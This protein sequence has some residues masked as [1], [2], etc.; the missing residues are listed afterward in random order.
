MAKPLADLLTSR[1]LRIWYDAFSLKVGDS[2]R[3][4]IEHGLERS[5]FGI[6]IISPNFFRKEWPQRELDML[7]QKQIRSKRKKILPVW[8]EVDQDLIAKKSLALVDLKATK[9][10]NGLEKV[11]DEIL[12]STGK[13][14]SVQP[15][16]SSSLVDERFKKNFS[17]KLFLLTEVLAHK[18][19]D[20]KANE[21]IDF[22]I[23]LVKERID[24]WDTASVKFA[25]K[26]L[27]MK[28][29]KFSETNGL[30]DLYSIFKDLFAR[31]YSERSQLLGEMVDSFNV[32]MLG[33]WVPLSDVE[34][35]EKAAKIM[36]KLAMDFL[37]TDVKI[38]EACVIAIDNLA[39]DMFEPEILSK[40]ILLA[41][42]AF[43]KAKEKSE[44]QSFV[45]GLSS[46]I[47]I[48]DTYAWDAEIE[49]Y[50]RDSIAYADWEQTTF[51]ISLGRF[52][53][54]ILYP[55]LQQTIDEQIQNYADFFTDNETD[56]QDLSYE[57]QL[58]ARRILAY[59]FL[60]PEIAKEIRSKV[61]ETGS[62]TAQKTFEKMIHRSPFLKAIYGD[63]EM[64]TTFDGLLKFFE[65]NAD[66]ENLGIGLTTY[67]F[68]MIDFTSKL[69]DS[70][71]EALRGIAQ[72][73]GV[74][75]DLELLDQG[76][77]FEMDSLVYLGEGQGNDMKKLAPFLS[78]VNAV[79]EIKRFS[80]GV[81]FG[82]RSLQRSRP[83][84]VA[85]QGA[86]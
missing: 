9:T 81:E 75:E 65:S 55:G 7:V 11:V 31:A 35:G 36:V 76:L 6:V 2:L 84:A 48:N 42:Y 54:E 40:E 21:L 45:D 60:R 26:E 12:A 53:D 1:G 10:S 15:E 17:D 30:D 86:E 69:K 68:A 74:S 28:L 82:L 4:K 66:R 50:L 46:D 8:H 3:R 77:T 61:L 78:E 62:S 19:S 43:E 25:T 14:A 71:K 41:A 64:I 63:S 83:S 23:M 22:I 57:T 51:G 5:N 58:L 39:G 44:L 67:N 34:R 70:D 24:K 72:K 18:R 59:E 16:T 32:I 85:T 13:L 49:T 79:L 52:R 56:D 20:W 73:F 29:Y 27:F 47:R 37:E 38:A 80:T 33:S